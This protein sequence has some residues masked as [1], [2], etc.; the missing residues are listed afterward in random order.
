MLVHFVRRRRVLLSVDMDVVPRFGDAVMA[1]E[2]SEPAMR[3][4]GVAWR[5]KP[6]PAAYVELMTEQEYS[7][8]LYG[9]EDPVREP[10]PGR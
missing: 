1:G 8:K 4:W 10:A 5:L 2:G 6:G 9:R 7:R 3:A